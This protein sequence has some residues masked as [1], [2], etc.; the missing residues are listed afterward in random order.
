MSGYWIIPELLDQGSSPR[1]CRIHHW[2][3]SYSLIPN[4][5]EVP[6]AEWKKKLDNDSRDTRLRKPTPN[7]TDT[8]QKG[9]LCHLLSSKQ[10]KSGQAQTQLF[11]LE[12]VSRCLSPTPLWNA[13]LALNCSSQGSISPWGSPPDVIGGVG[14]RGDMATCTA[15]TRGCLWHPVE[16]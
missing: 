7:V 14:P 1:L 8:G 3:M 16:G 9:P 15:I 11:G 12:S 4:C 5:Q 13:A 10:G 2:V 6:V